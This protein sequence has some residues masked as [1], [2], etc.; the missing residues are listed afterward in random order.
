MCIFICEDECF[1]EIWFVLKMYVIVGFIVR[2]IMK[3]FFFVFVEGFFFFF[4]IEDIVCFGNFF[5]FVFG[6]WVF[7][8][9]WVL[10]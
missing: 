1:C 3:F 2:N 5:E 8:F 7:V 10:F 6:F 4:V 9:V